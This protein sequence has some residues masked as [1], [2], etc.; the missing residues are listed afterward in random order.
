[1]GFSGLSVNN[2]SLRFGG[3]QALDGITFDVPA[4][5][6]CA[7]IGPNGAGK[8]SLFN[9]LT[10]LYRPQAGTAV[11]D[12]VD[13]L[14]LPRHKLAG[15]GVSRTFQNLALF[16]GLS[17]ADN[18]GIGAY[19]TFRSGA[20]DAI[21]RT[22]RLWR[23]E[24]QTSAWVAQLLDRLELTTVAE[25]PI[26]GLPYGTLKRIE[27]ARALAS[28]PKLL[29]LDEPAAGLNHAEVDEFSALL[30]AIAQESELTLL[31]VEHHM[32]LVNAISHHVIAL[33]FGKI[34][35]EGAPREV[36]RNQQVVDAYLGVAA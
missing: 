31:V 17:V 6:V 12:G 5:Q 27:L 14:R 7:V 36:A 21:I 29:L 20:L 11:W 13:L 18:V 25:E 30:K 34:L 4:G 1:M 35:A 15:S 33:N 8:T 3:I 24:R 9:V 16:D 22:P 23:A 19:S 10:G 2:I 32:A 26:G 28:Q